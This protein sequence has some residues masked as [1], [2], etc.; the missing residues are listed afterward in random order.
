MSPFAEGAHQA[1]EDCATSSRVTST[2]LGFLCRLYCTFP[3]IRARLPQT[4]RTCSCCAS[5]S[6]PDNPVRM[7]LD[8]RL[9][10]SSNLRALTA[11][12]L[13]I[14]LAPSRRGK[15]LCWKSLATLG[16]CAHHRLPF[17]VHENLHDT[18]CSARRELRV[19]IFGSKS[20]VPGFPSSPS[21]RLTPRC[22][23][24]LPHRRPLARAR[25]L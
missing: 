6:A 22:R 16:E 17:R 23:E 9:M 14:L 1:V 13:K 7:A 2:R 25:R 11:L 3:M 10:P 12:E 4:S 21:L 5:K 8:M 15:E 18:C 19:S 20:P 24:R